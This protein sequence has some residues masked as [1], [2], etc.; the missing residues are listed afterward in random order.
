MEWVIVFDD[1]EKALTTFP[2]NENKL[3]RIGT[4]QNM[5]KPSS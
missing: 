4:S 5:L 2:V 1:L 3:V